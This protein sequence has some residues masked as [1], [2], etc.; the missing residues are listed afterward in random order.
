MTPEEHHPQLSTASERPTTTG[1]ERKRMK[2]TFKGWNFTITLRFKRCF[3]CI[4]I[5]QL[6]ISTIIINVFNRLR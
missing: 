6:T 4:S 1:T 3:N 2:L 5:G